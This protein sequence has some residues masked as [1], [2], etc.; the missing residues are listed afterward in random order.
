M[1]KEGNVAGNY[2]NESTIEY[3]RKKLIC[4]CINP[5]VDVIK[6]FKSYLALFSGEYLEEEIKEESIEYDEYER[7]F[8]IIKKTN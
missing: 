3:L 4:S 6:Q 5:D 1:A 2:Y 8:T 7:K